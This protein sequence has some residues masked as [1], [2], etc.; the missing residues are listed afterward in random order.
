MLAWIESV[1]P[2]LVSC[3]RDPTNHFCSTIEKLVICRQAERSNTHRWGHTRQSDCQVLPFSM[4]GIMK[5]QL[6]LINPVICPRYG[7]TKPS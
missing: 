2:D 6:T 4:D 3:A 5:S 1:A 7:E